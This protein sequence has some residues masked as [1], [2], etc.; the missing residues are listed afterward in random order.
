MQTHYERWTD[1]ERWLAAKGTDG[2]TPFLLELYE[3]F[4][5][6]DKLMEQLMASTAY[7]AARSEERH[8]MVRAIER[9]LE[10]RSARGE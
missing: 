7:D 10:K 8:L 3:R 9:A 6:S 2:E 4:K 5:D 1:Y